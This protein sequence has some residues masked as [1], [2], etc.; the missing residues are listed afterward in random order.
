[1][2]EPHI[3][4]TEPTIL[5]VDGIRVVPLGRFHALVE[6]RSKP[7]EHHSVEYGWNDES[8]KEKWT[9]SCEGWSFRHDCRHIRAVD[10]WVAGKASVKIAED[11]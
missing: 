10:R 7:G 4:V 8:G 5:L 2:S 1:M 11:S 9:C 3:T 6:S